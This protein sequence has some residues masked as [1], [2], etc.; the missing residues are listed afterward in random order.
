VPP[1]LPAVATAAAAILKQE[2]TKENA[3]LN[4][5]H[6]FAQVAEAKL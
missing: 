4:S 1:Q 5:S 3:Y 6:F 2:R